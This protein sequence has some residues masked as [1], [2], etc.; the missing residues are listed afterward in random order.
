MEYIKTWKERCYYN[1]IPDEIPK[2]LAASGRAPSYKS[3][4][5]C[6]LRNDLLLSGLGFQPKENNALYKQIK[7]LNSEQLNLF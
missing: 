4:A 5:I 6:I 7:K 2:K 1:D 3:I